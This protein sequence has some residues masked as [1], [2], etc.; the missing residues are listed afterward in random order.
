MTD[1][2]ALE[3]LQDAVKELQGSRRLNMKLR[4]LSAAVLASTLAAGA[5]A[6]ATAT[7]D[8]SVELTVNPTL[9][10]FVPSTIDASIATQIN[11]CVQSNTLGD[12]TITASTTSGTFALAGA[13]AGNTDT[14]TYAING[15]ATPGAVNITVLNANIQDT[16]TDENTGNQAI[17][18]GSVESTATKNPDAYSQTVTFTVSAT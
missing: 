10:L 8:T 12:A 7:G 1:L 4:K 16:C 15:Q 14:V 5:M 17:S 3:R 13:T 6:Q 11:Y 18:F 9:D 2:F